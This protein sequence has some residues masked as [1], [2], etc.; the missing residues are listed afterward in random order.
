MKDTNYKM[1]GKVKFM[2]LWMIVVSMLLSFSASAYETYY[3]RD[4]N[5][6]RR[7]W[8]YNRVEDGSGD[9]LMIMCPRYLDAAFED[10]EIKSDR[11]TEIKDGYVGDLIVPEEIRGFPVVAIDKAGFY[12]S[13]NITSVTLHN[14]IAYIGEAA[15]H[16]CSKL[17][18][19]N[20]PDG[21]DSIEPGTFWACSS[22]TQI[23]LP[24]SVTEIGSQAF[25]GCSKLHSIVIPKNVS[26]IGGQAFYL[27]GVYDV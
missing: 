4:A 2:K 1:V 24:D 8:Y 16:S 15:F 9:K 3:Y 10:K 13:T 23:E 5:Y 12:A 21:I 11:Y 7:A 18:S 6:N 20:I 26:S 14:G 17:R 22:L 25:T 27:S 19:V